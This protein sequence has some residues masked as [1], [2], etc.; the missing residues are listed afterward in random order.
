MGGAGGVLSGSQWPGEGQA[1]LA[2]NKWQRRHQAAA[3]APGGSGGGSSLVQ[4]EQPESEASH[5]ARED[6]K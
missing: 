5:C 3:A 6:N 2:K 4:A 1:E